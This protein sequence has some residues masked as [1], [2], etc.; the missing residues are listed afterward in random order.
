MSSHYTRLKTKNP[1]GVRAAYV[2]V[3]GSQSVR[4]KQQSDWQFRLN[5]EFLTLKKQGWNIAFATLTYSDRTIPTLPRELFVNESE[6]RSIR[7][8]SRSDVQCWIEH[9]R[10][11]CAYHFGCKGD[12]AVRY[13][14]AAEYG[15][16]TH[17]PHYHA[18][19]GFPSSISYEKMHALCSYYWEHGILFPRSPRGDH[20]P[21]TGKDMLPFEVVGDASKAFSYVSKYVCKD[22]DFEGQIEGIKL[23]KGT[24]LYKNCQS[25][26]IQSKGLGYSIV[27]DMTDAQKLDAYQNGIY[28]MTGE[29]YAYKMPLYLKNKL[30]FDND[31]IIS[32][33]GKR[34][35]R[36]KASAFFDKHRKDIFKQ[37]A[38]YYEELFRRSRKASYYIDRGVEQ[39]QAEQFVAA[40]DVH[41]QRVATAF[42]FDLIG[43]GRVGEYYLGYAFVPAD[44]CHVVATQDELIAQWYQRYSEKVH[45]TTDILDHTCWMEFQAYCSLVLGANTFCNLVAEQRQAESDALSMRINDY[46]N[47]VLKGML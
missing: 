41:A 46:F 23:K 28:F 4:R 21:M 35:V 19:L 42:G 39:A 16:Q 33:S 20:N 17:R 8:F 31:Y 45:M 7:C 40:I 9:I 26:H 38:K 34:L 5:A 15:S 10:H 29:D 12:T 2:P 44:K 11:Y 36:R 14:V 43:S 47:N 37:K 32:S 13:F 30:I 18:V 27:K 3:G 25:F 1:A 22:L 24:H 6:Y